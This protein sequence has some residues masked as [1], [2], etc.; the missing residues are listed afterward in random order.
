MEA[1]PKLFLFCPAVSSEKNE[2]RVTTLD[3]NHSIVSNEL[4]GMGLICMLTWGYISVN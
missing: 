3:F 1:A 4:P 2:L